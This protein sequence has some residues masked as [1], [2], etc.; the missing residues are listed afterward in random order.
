VV[1]VFTAAI[2]GSDFALAQ[3]PNVKLLD[4]L[5]FV[6]SF[7]FGLG[8][9]AAVAVISETVWSVISP[10]GVAGVVTPFL[11]LG[12]LLFVVAGWAASRMWGKKLKVLSP[13]PVFIGAAMAIC[14]FAWDFETNAAT[15]LLEYWPQLT[16]QKLLV[17]EMVGAVF[18]ISHE[19]SDFLLG[20]ILIPLV[21]VLLPRIRRGD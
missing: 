16:I 3:F 11:V 17:T 1:A 19:V 5:V 10:W 9:G 7:V 12:E 13:S 18:A 8:T 20:M 6:A 4:T 2:I 21:I 14:A 15:A